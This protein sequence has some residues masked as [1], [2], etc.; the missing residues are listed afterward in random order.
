MK[1]VGEIDASFVPVERS[2]DDRSVLD[3][4]AGQPKKLAQS[5]HDICPGKP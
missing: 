3:N 1:C 4:D 2:F 5:Q